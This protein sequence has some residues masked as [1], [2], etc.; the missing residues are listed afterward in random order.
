MF[1]FFGAR[2]S[3]ALTALVAG[4][5]GLGDSQVAAVAT[6]KPPPQRRDYTPRDTTARYDTP[7]YIVHS[8]RADAVRQA[9]QR[10]WDGYYKY[11]FPHDSLRP[12]TNGYLDDRNGWGATAVDALST[13]LIMQDTK[14]V[15]QILNYIPTID[16]DKTD[17]SVSLF[18]TTIRYLGGL[19]SAY[20]LITSNVTGKGG[21]S[22]RAQAILKQAVHLA[23]NLKVAFDTQSGVPD[24]DLWFNPPRKSGSVHNAIATVGTLVLEWTRLSDITGNP[25]YG[26]LA[27]RAESYLLS[28]RPKLGEP[29]PGLLGTYLK[30]SNGQFVDSSGGWGGGDDSFYEYLIKMYLYDPSAFADYKRRWILAADS[31]MKYLVSHPSSRPDLTYLAMWR[32]SRTLDFVSQHLACFSGGNFILGGLTLNTPKYTSFG[33]ELV[34]SCHNTYTS[35]AT[36]IGPEIFRWEDSRF[37]SPSQPVPQNQSDF[38]AKSGFWIDS[39]YYVLRPEVIESYY[40][41]YRATGDPKYQEWAWDAFRSIQKVCRVGSGYSGVVNVN[42]KGGMGYTDVQ[43]TFWL[44]EVLKYLYLI[45][46]EDAEWQVKVGSGKNRFVYNTEAHPVRVRRD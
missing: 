16:F 17:T 6:Q 1:L 42:V 11:A 39:A 37:P 9:F 20:D 43:E 41:A 4:L 15:D 27:Q 40:Y 30:I 19:L 28:P 46:S 26:K 31:S 13:A 29:F 12:T 35:T 2:P 10:S 24:N 32:D 7:E 36:H 34:N 22:K 25:L 18:E 44:A 8:A 3:V 21:D 23:D 45:F 14:V 33:L 5:I 38:Y